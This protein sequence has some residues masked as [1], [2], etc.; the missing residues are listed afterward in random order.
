MPGA[1]GGMYWKLVFN[2]DRVSV[3]QDEDVLEMEGGGGCLMP[4]NCSL[5]NSSNVKFE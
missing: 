4:L 3:L 1:G 5:K 2:G